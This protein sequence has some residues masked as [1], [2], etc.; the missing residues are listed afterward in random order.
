MHLLHPRRTAHRPL[1]A[2]LVASAGVALVAS[3]ANAAPAETPAST[4]KAGAAAAS[5]QVGQLKHGVMGKDWGLTIDVGFMLAAD[6]SYPKNVKTLTNQLASHLTDYTGSATDRQAGPTA[7][8]LLAAV[9]LGADPGDFGGSDVRQWTLDLV[10]PGSAGFQ[11]GRLENA[12]GSD[13]SN[14]FSQAYGVL[15]LS[16]SGSVPQSTVAFL[17]KQ[18]CSAGYFR[19][20]E[21]TGTTCDQDQTGYDADATALA[22]EALIAA[23]ADGATVDQATIDA[24]ASWLASDQQ[25]NGS[26]E[27]GK[28]FGFNSNSTGLAAQALAADGQKAAQLQAAA[29]VA[30]L[31]VTKKNAKNGPAKPDIGAIAYDPAGLASGLKSGLGSSRSVWQRATPQAYFALVPKPLTTLQVR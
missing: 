30:S 31:Q 25:T 12:G 19:L 21:S 6:G 5:W 27:E 14:V 1:L 20:T 3:S 26:F 23:K 28:G 4:A 11:A 24:S 15:G 8:A 22:I 9:V 2:L 10:A 13:T 16:R 29:W 17:L 7:K 18:R